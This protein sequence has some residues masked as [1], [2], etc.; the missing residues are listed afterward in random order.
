MTRCAACNGDKRHYE[1]VRDRSGRIVGFH[2][3]GACTTC[4]GTGTR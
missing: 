3:L 1:P 4:R 2:D